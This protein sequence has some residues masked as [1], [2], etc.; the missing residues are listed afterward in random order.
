VAVVHAGDD[1]DSDDN[2]DAD[3]DVCIHLITIDCI[4]F[5]LTFDNFCGCVGTQHIFVKKKLQK[6]WSIEK[7]TLPLHP[8][9]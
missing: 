9:S 4:H 5:L 2:D 6:A 7:K 1:D 8:L 3:N